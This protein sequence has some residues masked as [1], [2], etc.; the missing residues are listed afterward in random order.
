[1]FWWIFG[2]VLV[3]FSVPVI[4][5]V[6]ATIRNPSPRRSA[7]PA[8]CSDL[9]QSIIVTVSTPVSRIRREIKPF[10]NLDSIAEENKARRESID[11]RYNRVQPW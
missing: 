4:V 5:V 3:L 2:G 11:R 6:I 1:M 7:S 9:P 10:S 8:P